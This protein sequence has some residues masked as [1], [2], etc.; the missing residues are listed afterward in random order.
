MT[1]ATM[2]SSPSSSKQLDLGRDD[3]LLPRLREEPAAAL[4]SACDGCFD[5]LAVSGGD[6]TAEQMAV[7]EQWRPPTPT[8]RLCVTTLPLDAADEFAPR[9][10]SVDQ[11][12]RRH[13]ATACTTADRAPRVRC[14]AAAWHPDRRHRLELPAGSETSVAVRLPE[15]MSEALGRPPCRQNGGD[16]WRS[17]SSVARSGKWSSGEQRLST[18]PAEESPTNQDGCIDG[19]GRLATLLTLPLTSFA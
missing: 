6:D 16:S 12:V 8:R 2:T 17:P 13:S 15:V 4:I 1:H 10:S 18:C 14:P 5:D 7:D 19:V 9:S 11:T 3:D